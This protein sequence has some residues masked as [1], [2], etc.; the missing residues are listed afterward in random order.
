M[1]DLKDLNNPYAFV[2]EDA[3]RDEGIDLSHYA[4]YTQRCTDLITTLENTRAYFESL[5]SLSPEELASLRQDSLESEKVQ[6]AIAG[7]AADLIYQMSCLR[8]NTSR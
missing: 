7:Y 4:E 5:Q 8:D 3:P 2:D 1:T 6:N